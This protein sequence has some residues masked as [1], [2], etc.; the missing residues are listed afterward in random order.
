MFLLVALEPIR[1]GVSRRF[2]HAH[3]GISRT[4][5]GDWR[6]RTQARAIHE[7]ERQT[8]YDVTREAIVEAIFR[9]PAPPPDKLF[10]WFRTVAS[11][12]ALIQLRKDLTEAKTSMSAA[13]A[14]RCS[15]RS[16]GSRT[17]RRRRCASV[18][19]LGKWRRSFELRA[20]YE[21]VEAFY[22]Q[23]AVRRACTAAIGRLP[24]VQAEV[25]DGLFRPVL[26]EPGRHPACA[27]AQGLAQHDLQQQRQ[28]EEEHGERRL[29]LHRVV[30]ARDPARPDA[31]RGD[32]R[33]LSERA[34]AR[35]PADRRHRPG[36]VGDES[37]VRDRAGQLDCQQPCRLCTHDAEDRRPPP[38]APV[39]PG[40]EDEATI[41]SVSGEPETQSPRAQWLNRRLVGQLRT[42]GVYATQRASASSSL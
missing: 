20:I 34:V 42:A 39:I 31:C 3:G 30:P 6:D 32:L 19:A 21:T 35:P 24:R 22:H 10:P 9:Y 37:P 29:L 27:R 33:P 5:V 4:E 11:R 1:R 38:A 2:I 40:G 36:G 16:R 23:G 28:S 15:W 14:G 41:P 12:H 18:R 13:E 25:I 7:I 26:P 17:P 8:L